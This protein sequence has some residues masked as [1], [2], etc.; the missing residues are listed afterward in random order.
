MSQLRLPLG[1]DHHSSCL[2]DDYN[3]IPK[4]FACTRR[5]YLN[6]N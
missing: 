2:I 3:V 5:Y 6:S 4:A 1:T